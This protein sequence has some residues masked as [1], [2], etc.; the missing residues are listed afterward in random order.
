V[1]IG[2][3]MSIDRAAFL[4]GLYDGE[5][6]GVAV[7]TGIEGCSEMSAVAQLN[8][9]SAS[10]E[11]CV[12]NVRV[13]DIAASNIMGRFAPGSVVGVRL[14]DVEDA[15][16]NFSHTAITG[17]TFVDYLTDEELDAGLDQFAE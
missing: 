2:K 5:Y 8:V 12:R 16:G 3:K 17:F 11:D 1:E 10:E 13:A 4:S 15:R 6:A 7:V 9:I 14:I